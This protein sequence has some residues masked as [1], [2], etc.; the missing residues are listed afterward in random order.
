MNEIKN[1]IDTALSEMRLSPDFTNRITESR[2]RDCQTDQPDGTDACLSLTFSPF[3]RTGRMLCQKP[4]SPYAA[5]PRLHRIATAV[6]FAALLGTSAFAAGS[7]LYSR[8]SVNQQALP[9]LDP[10]EVIP[11]QPVD[12]TLT[13]YGQLKKTYTSMDALEDELGVRLLGTKPTTDNPYIKIFYTK[14]GDGYNEINIR[15]Y[16]LGDLTDFRAWNGEEIDITTE[17][18]DQWYVWT[19]GTIYKSPV[20]LTIKI[21]SDPSQQ[22][23]DMEYMGY[24]Q[25]VETFTSGQ[26]YTVNVLQDTFSEDQQ[27]DL[28]DDFVRRTHMVFV[29]DGIQ[30]TLEGRVPIQTMKEIIDTM[31]Y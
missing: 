27:S 20:N 9:E 4:A 11:L 12:G 3:H 18:N 21:I 19:Q 10:M 15:E 16:L 24:F 31:Q 13:E 6:L 14:T 17:G 7:L 30:Y 25:Y 28:S 1:C 8:I 23:L 29:A 2:N 22:E 26:G 5:V